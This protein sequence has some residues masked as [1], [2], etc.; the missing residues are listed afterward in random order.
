MKKIIFFLILF[1]INNIYCWE[2]F[3]P[4]N[5]PLLNTV[6]RTIHYDSRGVLWIVVD[7]PNGP[8]F[9]AYENGKFTDYTDKLASFYEWPVRQIEEDAR[10]NRIFFT[11]DGITVF[12]GVNWEHTNIK[13]KTTLMQYVPRIIC[14]D[15]KIFMFHPRI[16][17][18]QYF[19]YDK[20]K[21]KYN[22]DDTLSYQLNDLTTNIGH[23]KIRKLA[24]K[25]DSE[26]I[27][28]AVMGRSLI[29]YNFKSKEWNYL[30][31]DNGN[32]VKD[33]M[34][35]YWANG[36]YL[37]EDN[38]YYLRIIRDELIKVD[39]NNHIDVIPLE[40]KPDSPSTV[41]GMI[42]LPNKK[43]I[44]V[45]KTGGMVY[46]DNDGKR[47][48]IPK[49][50]HVDEYG[51]ILHSIDYD[52]KYIWIGTTYNGLYRC[53]LDE[54]LVDMIPLSVE[55]PANVPSIDIFNLYPNPVSNNIINV[56][57]LLEN[58]TQSDLKMQLYDIDGKKV[59]VPRILE[60]QI[61]ND[62]SNLV[63]EIPV[64]TKGK[65]FIT[66]DNKKGF[67]AKSFIIE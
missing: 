3:T 50:K 56:E 32:K 30:I 65:Y 24:S 43:G 52:G 57:M 4:S 12:D 64:L 11:K 23:G 29:E 59:G 38:T 17:K 58:F 46:I 16:D 45:T 33:K 55:F 22:L 14:Y 67:R 41:S 42:V 35:F 51:W 36:N 53:T 20:S 8:Q 25:E 27:M 9:L 44:F 2:N 13:Y 5:S 10:G 48:S 19:Q 6:A 66:F 39:T 62:C 34:N 7:T 61:L 60:H 15:D 26:H 49:P 63:L 28:I 37:T 47:F 31:D 18:L 40:G 1:K 21:G 54:L